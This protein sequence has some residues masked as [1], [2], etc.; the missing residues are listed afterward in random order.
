MT[1]R[2]IGF[3]DFIRFV[4]LLLTNP[5]LR[6]AIT[7][8]EFLGFNMNGRVLDLGCGPNGYNT[9][10]ASGRAKQVISIDITVENIRKLVSICKS[11]N[12]KNVYPI[13]CD[14]QY[15][16]FRNLCFDKIF[17]TELLEHVPNDYRVCLEVERVLKVGGLCLVSV[18]W[19]IS[20]GIYKNLD[21]NHFKLPG[22]HLRGYNLQRLKAIFSMIDGAWYLYTGFHG[23]ILWF[24]VHFFKISSD[25]S[26][27]AIKKSRIIRVYEL[28]W[29]LLTKLHM[30]T[31]VDF[32][33]SRV[34]PKGIVMMFEK[35]PDKK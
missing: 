6:K 25:P 27:G 12:L 17:C 29:Q 4:A 14:A 13:V 34:L 11:R 21:P 20:E 32:V 9:L 1:Q 19:Y 30:S 23:F 2:K 3:R 31:F 18:P 33:G 28:F 8:Y 5:K 22:T 35:H 16:P 24:I 15:L 26:I 10:L 7:F